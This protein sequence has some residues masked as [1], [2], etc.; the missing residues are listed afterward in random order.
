MSVRDGA[1]SG[2][3]VVTPIKNPPCADDRVRSFRWSAYRM[4]L[5]F[6]DRRTRCATGIPRSFRRGPVRRRA[7]TLPHSHHAATDAGEGCG[8]VGRWV[9][10][11][12]VR[13]RPAAPF[14][15]PPRPCPSPRPR[16]DRLPERALARAAVTD[17]SDGSDAQCGGRCIA[18]PQRTRA[19]GQLSRRSLRIRVGASWSSPF[20]I[21]CGR[22]G[23]QFR[24]TGSLVTGYVSV[25]LISKGRSHP[26]K[27]SG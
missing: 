2:R 14:A 25:A 21:E 4:P 27:T 15:G 1:V 24:W 8:S 22:L 20:R 3:S 19:R 18:R 26:T 13:Q 17:P 6:S 5:R 23:V 10:L 16:A 7:R 11:F 12:G 9:P